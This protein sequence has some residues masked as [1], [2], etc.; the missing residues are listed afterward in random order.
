MQRARR[1]FRKRIHRIS[2]QRIQAH[3]QSRH[4]SQNPRL[5]IQQRAV[6]DQQQR[7]VLAIEARRF[8]Q[9]LNIRP[10]RRLAARNHDGVCLS[11]NAL[12]QLDR[13]SGRQFLAENIRLFLCAITP[14]QITFVGDVKRNRVGRHDP[15]PQNVPPPRVSKVKQKILRHKRRLPHQLA[16]QFTF[17]PRSLVQRTRRQRNSSQ[18]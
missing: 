4:R 8:N 18:P 10:H 3:N 12:Q 16:Q 1:R 5:S 9:L 15:G 13:L 14:G 11:S 7:S 6:G 17:R 2:R